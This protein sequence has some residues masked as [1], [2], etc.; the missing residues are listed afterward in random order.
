MIVSL[1]DLKS[2]L[3]ID[4][5]DATQ[6]DNLTRLIKAKTAWV[7][8]ATQRR[9][10]TP[11]PHTQIECGSG[12]AELYLEW[13]VDDVVYTPPLTPSPSTSVVVSRRP[14]LERYRAW[15]LLVEG[16][17]WERRGQTLY[18]LRAWTLWPV[19]DEFKIDYL[20]GYGIAPD[21]I[22]ELILELARNQYLIDTETSSGT[23]GITSEKIGDF[24]YSVGSSSSTATG[25]STVS[26]MGKATIQRYKRR[27]V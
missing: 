26:D 21:D 2:V 18:F 4:E 8:G 14:V 20:G 10:D 19:Q 23:S 24:S 16:T 7:E 13:H 27:F 6:D 22:K 1:D 17:D 25:S 12:E 5:D 15:E 3:G 11:I 9:F